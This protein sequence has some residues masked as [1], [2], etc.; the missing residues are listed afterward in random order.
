MA[1]PV[2]GIA[3]DTAANTPFLSR[4]VNNIRRVL[5][6]SPGGESSKAKRVNEIKRVVQELNPTPLNHGGS[7]VKVVLNIG[8]SPP[9]NPYNMMPGA[10]LHRV[11]I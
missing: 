9:P 1:R 5:L 3:Q 10:D 11:K 4:A 2:A 6:G 7:E 8:P